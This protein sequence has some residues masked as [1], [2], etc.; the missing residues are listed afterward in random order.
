MLASSGRPGERE[1]VAQRLTSY[2]APAW[3]GALPRS[4]S[5]L[6]RR[7]Y[8]RLPWLDL[9][10][11]QLDL[12]DGLSRQ[13]QKAGLPIRA[14]E[15]LFLQ[16]VAATAGGLVGALLAWE[17]FGGPL[18]VL[19]CALLGFVAPLPWLRLKASQRLTAFEQGLPDALDRVTGAL[20][21]GYGLEYGL[22]I[23][24][25][26]SIGPCAEEFGQ[27]LQELNL[28]GGHAHH[29]D[30]H[31]SL[32]C[33]HVVRVTCW[34]HRGDGQWRSRVG[35]AVLEPSDCARG[36]LMDTLLLPICVLGTFVATSALVLALTTPVDTP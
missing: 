8:S 32:L 21:A 14:G 12:A 26:E 20:R 13:L 16:L 3:E 1:I 28:G 30:V 25:R 19:A 9:V 27:V 7:R 15:F 24:S 31:Q 23:V 34:S 35:W 2:I 4:I 36:S 33:G 29:H 6:R 18:A 10:L 11:A 17:Q 22:D 5:V